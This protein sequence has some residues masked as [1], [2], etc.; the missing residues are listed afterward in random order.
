[1]TDTP[2]AAG[3]GAKPKTSALAV[4]RS[5]IGGQGVFAV[6][7]VPQG[8]VIHLMGGERVGF[9]E[10]VARIATGRLGIDDPLPIGRRTFIVLDQFSNRFNHS[11][12][13]NALLRHEAELFAI[14]DIAAGREI[15]FDY[16]TTLRRSF[17]SRAWRMPCNC[18]AATCRPF[19]SDVATIP[20]EQLYRYI[21][22]GGLQDFIR[23]DLGHKVYAAG[24]ASGCR[25]LKP[26]GANRC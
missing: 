1:M 5:A 9:I 19:I 2:P 23:A 3:A 24:L 10:C 14:E 22:V 12:A 18:G 15:T 25:S 17:Y 13:P 20:I 6:S 4:A 8:T 11:C 26:P 7:A 21:R 16:A